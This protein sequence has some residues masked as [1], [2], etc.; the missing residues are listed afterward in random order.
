MKRNVVKLIAGLAL[1]LGLASG[2][3]AQGTK[4]LEWVSYRSLGTP[5]TVSGYNAFFEGPMHELCKEM[6]ERNSVATGYP[7]TYTGNFSYKENYGPAWTFCEY[8]DQNGKIDDFGIGANCTRWAWG[9]YR[10][11]LEQGRA[12]LPNGC[13]IRKSTYPTNCQNKQIMADG[14]VVCGTPRQ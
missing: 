9:E 12:D 4:Y 14:A 2:A 8:K 5:D 10:N 13:Y 6:L 3:M 1:G 11:I 7:R